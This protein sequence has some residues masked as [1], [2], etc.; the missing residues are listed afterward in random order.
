MVIREGLHW[1]FMAAGLGSRAYSPGLKLTRP[2]AH[3]GF[4]RNHPKLDATKLCVLRQADRAAVCTQATASIRK[5]ARS[6]ANARGSR[7][8]LGKGDATETGGIGG[9]RVPGRRRHPS[10]ARGTAPQGPGVMTCD[11][12]PLPNPREPHGPEWPSR[13][14]NEEST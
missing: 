3:R 12:M 4:H 7:R 2:S 6:P 10:T 9:R 11:V 8:H 5:R 1:G 14:A 13:R